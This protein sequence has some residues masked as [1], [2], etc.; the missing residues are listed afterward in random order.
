MRRGHHRRRRDEEAGAEISATRTVELLDEPDVRMSSAVA[1]AAENRPSGSGNCE[2]PD[3]AEQRPQDQAPAHGANTSQ[4]FG[5][6]MA[7][8]SSALSSTSSSTPISRATSRS[9]RPDFDASFDDL[10]RPVVADVRVERCRRRERQLGVALALLAICLDPAHALVGEEARCRREQPDRVE[11]VPRHQRDEDVELE[12]AL[13]PADRDRGVVTDHLS[14]DLGHDLGDDRVDLAGHDRG[15]LLE[16]RQEDLGKPRPRPRPE[17]AQ[18][19]CDLGERDGDGLERAGGLDE[20]VARGLRLERVGRRVDREAGLCR[21]PRANALG[22]L[23]MGVQPGTDCSAAER[24]L[25]E[26][27]ERRGH[28]R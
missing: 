15:A 17:E 24:D 18:V 11:E 27:L 7:R 13:H 28:A 16:L 4:P 26:P 12:V 2:S 8:K 22:E 5:L 23:G 14:R 25:A 1:R 9:D 10:A 20:A 3:Q 6:A 19:V 21:E